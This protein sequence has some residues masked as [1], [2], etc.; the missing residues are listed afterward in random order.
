MYLDESPSLLGNLLMGGEPDY[1]PGERPVW[2]VPV[3]VTYGRKG[4]AA[5]VNVDAHTGDSLIT[6]ETPAEVLQDVHTF[7]ASTTSH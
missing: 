5:F 4:S 1:V 2:R 3:L 6:D 7:L